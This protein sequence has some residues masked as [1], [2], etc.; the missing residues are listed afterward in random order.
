[1]AA[2]GLGYYVL[3]RALLIIPTILILYTI[4]FILLRI[5]PGNPIL[6]VVGTRNIPE[7]QLQ[8]LMHMAG[9][10]KPLYIQYFD[11]LW[12]VLHGDFGV[13]LAI[14]QGT[15]VI[16]YIMLRFPATLELTI[17]GFTISVLLGLLTGVVGAVKRGTI[18]DSSMRL[19]S[20]IA[21]T[22]FIPWF[23]LMLQYLFG[24]VLGILPT[25]GRL[26]PGLH[27]ETPTGLYVLDSIITGNWAALRSA[28][29]HLVLPSI[30]LGIVLSGAYTRLV[31]NNMI[32]V[33][34]Q[35]FIRSYH[36]RGVK[37]WKVTW[38]ALKNAFIPIV[39]LMGLQFAILLGGAVLTETT[40][41]WPGMGTFIV[42]R[43]EYRDYASIQGAIIFFAIFVSIISLIV[44]I[45]YALLDPRVK[46]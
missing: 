5:L 16:D 9:L 11:Y 18:I 10:D 3:I 19:Y 36:A 21:Y 17:F 46:Y 34:S 27:L 30:T 42:D 37:G 12:R 15:P 39:T 26:D 33:L 1:M 41:S 4:V 7:E 32:D 24:V 40:F 2:R 43:L 35:D 28:L 29:A 13:T 22:L 23:G 20:I 45:I 44:D 14:P 38:Y 25:S 8:H 31:R 6:A